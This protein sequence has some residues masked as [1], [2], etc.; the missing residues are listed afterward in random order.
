MQIEEASAPAIEEEST[1]EASAE[2]PAPAEEIPKPVVRSFLPASRQ[3]FILRFKQAEEAPE[4]AAEEVLK[5][6]VCY[7]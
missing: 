1:P 5:D 3:T 7:L 2:E 6:V 4:H